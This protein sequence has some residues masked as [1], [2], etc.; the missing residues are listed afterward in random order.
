MP[1]QPP[2]PKATGI[3]QRRLGDE[4][5]LE[6]LAKI[7]AKPSL[8]GCKDLF[9]MAS[10][11]AGSRGEADLVFLRERKERLECDLVQAK[12]NGYIDPKERAKLG[13]IIRKSKR[14]DCRL[15]VAY[16]FST[17]DWRVVEV[18]TQEEML[19]KITRQRDW[20]NPSLSYDLPDK[21]ENDKF[22]LNE[23]FAM[24]VRSAVKDEAQEVMNTGFF[25]SES[26]PVEYLTSYRIE[27][28]PGEPDTVVLCVDDDKRLH[29][30]TIHMLRDSYASP[31]E[32]ATIKAHFD[33]MGRVCN[34]KQFIAYYVHG[35]QWK[36]FCPARSELL[37]FFRYL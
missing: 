26:G 19:S 2:K 6:C 21:E 36:M 28:K 20:D 10:R 14:T 33:M 18:Q 31:E 24:T 25:E 15:H 16:Y 8:V 12:R 7:I 17:T 3:A 5:E 29:V 9:F 1:K 35:K 22:R 30:R 4:F 37:D 27:T 13:K 11:T 23:N 32:F 34:F